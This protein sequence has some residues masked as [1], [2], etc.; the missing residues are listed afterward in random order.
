MDRTFRIVLLA[1]CLCLLI[2]MTNCQSGKTKRNISEGS[3]QTQIQTQ[4]G[5]DFTTEFNASKSYAL[6][7]Q[8]QDSKKIGTQ[9][10]HFIILRLRDTVVVHV[11]SYRSGYVKWISDN[12]VEKLSLPGKVKPDQDMSVY[13]K[14]IRVDQS[15]PKL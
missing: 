13:K 9:N 11:D 12:A 14:I 10:V 1:L 3:A 6:L 5:K 7:R 2:M 15:I 8:V 4:L